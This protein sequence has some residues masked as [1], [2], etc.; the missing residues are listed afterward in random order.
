MKKIFLCIFTLL[1][2]IIAWGSV[3]PEPSVR[4]ETL[5]IIPMPRKVTH[6][7]G[8]LVQNKVKKVKVKIDKTMAPEAYVLDINPKGIRVKAG[9][10]QGA[11]YAQQS[12]LQLQESGQDIPCMTIEDAP[13]FAYRGFMLDVSRHFFSVDEI[14]KFI[15][16]M[17]RYKMNVFHWHLTD[18]QGFRAEIKRYPLLTTIGATR[19]DNYDTP[20]CKIEQNGQTYWTG[21]GAKTGKS[22]GPYFY[23]QKEMREVVRYAAERYIDVLPEVDMPGHFV[24]ALAAYPEY[25]CHPESAPEVWHGWGVSN[26]VLNVANP[27]AVEFAQN[28]LAE[29][30]EIF[31]YPYIHIGGDECP[32]SQWQNNMACQ[33]LFQQQGLKN[34]RELQTRFIKQIADFVATKGRKLF[35]WNESV[36]AGGADL[37]LMKQTDATIM[38]W[39][40]C[41]EGVHKAVALGLNAIVTEYHGKGGGYYINRRQ[42]NEPGE[43]SGA[44]YGDDTVEGCYNYIPIQGRYTQEELALIKG[45]QATFWTEHVGTNEYLEY[46]ALPRLICVAESGW[47]P[48]ENKDWKNFRQRLTTHT[49]WLDEKGFVYARHWMENYIPRK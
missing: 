16:L 35:C 46:L 44:G 12:I 7:E 15:D 34:Y 23:T 38:S 30:I 11:F 22:Y 42:S 3:L 28:I 40:P 41:Q 45:V 13:R 20:I 8:V 36:T 48:Q 17:A 32:T 14:K 25:S 2:T 31:P 43:P 37:E 21:Q 9:S 19:T 6:H 47:T 5:P 1:T 33:V 10:K 4:T 39:H 18:D 27:K 24:S 29:L 26:D 49:K